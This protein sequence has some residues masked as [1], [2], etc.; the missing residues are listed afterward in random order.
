MPKQSFSLFSPDSGQFIL[1]WPLNKH[2]NRYCL[3]F[4]DN[5]SNDHL[6]Y[7]KSSDY[8]NHYHTHYDH[9]N[10]D[11][12]YHDNAN[13]DHANDDHAYHDHTYHDQSYNPVI[14]TNDDTY[15]LKSHSSFK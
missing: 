15:F 11:H 12:A 8:T 5:S 7:N 6:Y 3:H 13:H 2:A 1:V 10:H 9:A 14:T 4:K